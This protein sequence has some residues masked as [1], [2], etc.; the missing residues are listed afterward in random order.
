MLLYLTRP[1]RSKCR[2][3]DVD[4][5]KFGRCLLLFV[6]EVVPAAK[7]PHSKIFVGFCIQ[8]LYLIVECEQALVILHPIGIVRNTTTMKTVRKW[9]HS[10][11]SQPRNELL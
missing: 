4:I 11:Y 6:F 3:L 2:Q 1:L 5:S 7:E 9:A 8:K 10:R